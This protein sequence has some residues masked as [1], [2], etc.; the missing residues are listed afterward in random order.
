MGS[1]DWKPATATPPAPQGA[2]TATAAPQSRAPRVVR[3]TKPGWYGLKLRQRGD[4]FELANPDKDYS[5][6]SRHGKKGWMQPLDAEMPPDAPLTPIPDIAGVRV[7]GPGAPVVGM[8]A[9]ASVSVEPTGSA[10][11]LE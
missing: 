5:D 4:V 7:G 10:N 8:G 6:W 3:A 9:G 2:G 11:V 1:K